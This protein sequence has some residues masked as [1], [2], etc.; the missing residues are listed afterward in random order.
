MKDNQHNKTNQLHHN[1]NN[2]NPHK[3][4]SGPLLTTLNSISTMPTPSQSVAWY[5]QRPV[6]NWIINALYY[7]TDPSN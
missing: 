5:E 7:S 1:I 4:S 3:D 6:L 2:N